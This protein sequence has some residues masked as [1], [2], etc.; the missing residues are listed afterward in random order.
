MREVFDSDGHV[1][2]ATPEEVN[3]QVS[4]RQS[5]DDQDIDIAFNDVT[6]HLAV[7]LDYMRTHRAMI[8]VST[9]TSSAPKARTWHT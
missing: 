6:R 2:L 1:R 7:R 4:L 8:K 5:A 3:I 9:S